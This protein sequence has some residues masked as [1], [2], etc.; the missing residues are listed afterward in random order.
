VSSTITIGTAPDSWGVWFPND[1][2]QVPSEVFLREVA[3][4][5]YQWIELGPY[6]YLPTDPAKLSEQLDEYGMGV[7]AGTVFEHLHRPNSWDAV[8]DSGHRRRG[9]NPSPRGKAHCGDTGGVA[10]PQDRLAS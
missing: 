4:A 8:L 5:G 7:L 9:T 3:E 1:P 6:G 10:T 2:E